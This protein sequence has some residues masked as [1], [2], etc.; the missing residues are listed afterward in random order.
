MD[1]ITLAI[2]FGI[3]LALAILNKRFSYA[4]ALSGIGILMLAFTLMIEPLAIQTGYTTIADTAL[5]ISAT[6]YDYTQI[7]S[8]LNLLISLILAGAGLLITI[9]S[10]IEA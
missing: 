2:L 5:N 4:G 10:A 8:W 6:T 7:A 3:F 1:I 9:R